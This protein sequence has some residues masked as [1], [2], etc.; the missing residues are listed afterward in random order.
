[1]KNRIKLSVFLIALGSTFIFAQQKCDVLKTDISG[2]YSGDCKN[3][4]A[5]GKGV[6]RG[7]NVYEGEFKKGLPTG[8]GTII[9]ADGGKYKGEWKNGVRHGEGVYS[10]K[11]E[12][13]DS[14][15][16]GIWKND[17]YVGKK[18]VIQYEVIKQMSVS[19]YT[20]RK[21]SDLKNQVTIKVRQNGQ[22]LRNTY[23]NVT[24]NSGVRVNY[25]G[26]VVFEN[27]NYY[28][29]SCDMRYSVSS[30]FGVAK[31][32]V[33]FFFKILAEGEWVV[34]INH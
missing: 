15:A 14:I 1:M 19:R 30:K 32:D 18:P 13:K 34:E 24:S 8:L 31:I 21:V 2:E 28:P 17:A 6:S 10:L 12:G 22:A 4:L 16:D 33:E 25:D 11:V 9:Y 26:Y 3:G 27:I 5:H 20:I 7:Q 29:F 23:N